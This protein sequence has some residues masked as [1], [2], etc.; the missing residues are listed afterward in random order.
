MWDVLKAAKRLQDLAQELEHTT[1]TGQDPTGQVRLVM[2]GHQTIQAIQIDP[3]LLKDPEALEKALI[4]AYDDARAQLQRFV[5]EKLGTDL[6]F[7]LPG[8]PGNIGLA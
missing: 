6:P 1:L 2:T 5:I 7:S 8:L 3:A 4:Q